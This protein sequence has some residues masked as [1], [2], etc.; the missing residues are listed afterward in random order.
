MTTHTRQFV[1]RLKAAAVIKAE[2]P[3]TVGKVVLHVLYSFS[4]HNVRALSC[5]PADA[6]VVYKS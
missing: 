2:R 5:F 3:T 6:A 1:Y 4:R